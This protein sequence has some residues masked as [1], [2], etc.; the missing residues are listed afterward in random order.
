MLLVVSCGTLGAR[1]TVTGD[2]ELQK[3]ESSTKNRRIVSG[4]LLGGAAVNDCT[5]K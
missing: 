2:A 3:H 4:C 1:S 5:A